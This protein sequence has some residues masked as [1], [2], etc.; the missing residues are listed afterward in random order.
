MIK[1]IFLL[2]LFI[3]QFTFLQAGIVI[4]NGL[5]HAYKV[6]NGKVYKGKIAIE[7]T[8]NNPQNVKLFLQDFGYQADGSISYTSLHTNKK[9]NGDW[10]K[11]NTNLIT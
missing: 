1:R 5:T 7:N 4:L 3:L 6:E 9:T 10:I 8:G 11:L 2:I